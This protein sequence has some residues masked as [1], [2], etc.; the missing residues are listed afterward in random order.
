MTYNNVSIIP[1]TVDHIR[2]IVPI[3]REEDLREIDKWN[4]K[5]F[6]GIWRSY[7]NS[8]WCNSL[9]IGDQILAIG[10]LQGG[11]LGFSANPWLMTS[12]LVDQ[13]PLVFASLYR[14]EIKKMLKDYSVLE[15]FCD[16]AYTKSLK[17]LKIIGFKER[18]FVPTRKGLLVRLEMEAA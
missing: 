1:T 8:K 11:L 16:S 6:K 18:E 7:K 12:R 9:F 17:M 3:L 10:G 2:Q 15:T 13:Y 5:P 14:K 4:V